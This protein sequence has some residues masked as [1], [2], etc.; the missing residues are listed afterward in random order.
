MVWL[1]A[2]AVALSF[3]ISLVAVPVVRRMARFV[4]LVDCPDGERKLH[5]SPIA[6]AGGVAVLATV[7]LTFAG[8][9]L[10][11]RLGGAYALG[12]VP[13]QWY[14][15]F[16]AA[17]ALLLVGLAD[18]AF[19]LRG[20][21]KLLFQLLVISVLVVSGTTVDQI[22]LFG[23]ELSLGLLAI[24]V[25]VLWLLVAVNA[26]NL[27]DG[28]DGV[29]TTAGCI[30]SGGL[31]VLSIYRGDTFG[32]VASAA[33]AG[34]LLG[35]LVFNRPPATIFLGDAGSMLIGLFVGVLAMWSSVK[36]STALASAPVAI[37]AI[38]LFDSAAAI[39]RRRLTGRSIYATDRAHLHH[40]LQQKFG[41]VGMLWMVAGLCLTT[42]SFSFLSVALQ[43]DWLAAV[44]VLMA[45]G[46][47]VGTRSF[48]HSEFQL[49]SSHAVHLLQSFV[50]RRGNGT[51]IRTHQLQGGG[52][53]DQIWE[54]L[55]EFAQLHGLASLKID[56]SFPWLHE[57][58][59][60]TWH[61]ARL[62]EKAMQLS[63]RLPLFANRLGEPSQVPVGRLEI[64]APAGN[65]DVYQQVSEFTDKLAD[66][67][68]QLNAIVAELELAGGLV[69][70]GIPEVAELANRPAVASRAD[71]SLRGELA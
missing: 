35:F 62:P 15:L 66:L 52:R 55:V 54:P 39:V 6:L 68:P 12:Y 16:A 53:W 48:G 41:P 40:L 61:S 59:H 1:I 23:Y 25:S 7:L 45:I 37:L 50:T 31:A 19:S 44:G 3:S 24:P 60:A 18:D 32:G 49:L 20:R 34:A 56:L 70:P 5:R 10:I 27:I 46:M 2:T 36:Q 47:L 64:I 57:G 29:A 30:I 38:P 26:L 33:L 42:T 71:P 51:Q 22:S 69:A 14:V 67:G 11:D 9:V 8:T 65:A 13:N 21:Q 43:A 58:Y 4:G 17:T 28:A 63:I